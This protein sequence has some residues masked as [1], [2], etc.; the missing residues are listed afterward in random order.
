MLVHDRLLRLEALHAK[1][2]CDLS[3]DFIV[4]RRV[5]LATDATVARVQGVIPDLDKELEVF[6]LRKVYICVLY[7]LSNSVVVPLRV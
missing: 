1:R 4:P 6:L 5:G 7:R 2:R 3:G